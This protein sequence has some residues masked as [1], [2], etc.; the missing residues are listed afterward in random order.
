M[1]LDPERVA[2]RAEGLTQFVWLFRYPGDPDTPAPEEAQDALA[3][4]RE[5]Y[6]AVL[7]RLPLEVRP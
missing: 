3:L 6:G 5:V 7:Q 4:A 2:E 1:Q